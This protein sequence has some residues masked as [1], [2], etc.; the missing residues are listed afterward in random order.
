MMATVSKGIS[1]AELGWMAGVIDLKGRIIRKKNK[2][3]ATPQLVLMV[4]SAQK[5]VIK[6]LGRLTGT[7]PEESRQGGFKAGWDRRACAE[8][9]PDDHVHV[10][11]WAYPAVSRWT[12]TG[13]A[14]GVVLWN[15]SPLLRNDERGFMAVRDEALD[16]G[17]LYGR[18]SG[19]TLAALNRLH[20]L[21]W[22]FPPEVYQRMVSGHTYVETNGDGG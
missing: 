14:M 10:D 2:K 19:A 13:T 7:S 17:A 3:R 18:G 21:G 15:L 4:E 9:C 11:G 1:P 8:H 20:A 22:R 5:S 16:Q 12:L 6:E